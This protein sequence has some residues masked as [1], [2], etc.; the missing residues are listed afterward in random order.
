MTKEGCCGCKKND[1]F[2]HNGIYCLIMDW[3][4]NKVI[5]F[6]DLLKKENKK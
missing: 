1:Y 6:A 3:G 4:E 5:R 2:K